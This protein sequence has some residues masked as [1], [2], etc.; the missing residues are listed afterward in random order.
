MSYYPQCCNPCRLCGG[1]PELIAVGY[2]RDHNDIACSVC[3]QSASRIE[4]D[5]SERACRKAWNAANPQKGSA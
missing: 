1:K 2:G 4:V 5:G 3:H